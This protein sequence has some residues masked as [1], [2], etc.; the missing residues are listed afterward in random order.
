MELKEEVVVNPRRRVK[1]KNKN[2]KLINLISLM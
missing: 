1:R 2:N